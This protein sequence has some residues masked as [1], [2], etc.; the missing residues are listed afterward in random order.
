MLLFTV[1]S[2]FGVSPKMAALRTSFQDIDQVAPDN[3]A[4]IEFQALHRWSERLEGGVLLLGIAAAFA[5]AR[6]LQ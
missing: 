6:T 2:Q 3:P 5:L 4:R 1:I